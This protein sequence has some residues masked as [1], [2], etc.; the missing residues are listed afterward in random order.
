MG[1]GACAH[2]TCLTVLIGQLSLCSTSSNDLVPTRALSQIAPSVVLLV[3]THTHSLVALKQLSLC[4][5]SLFNR[6][7][8]QFRF[9]SCS[10]CLRSLCSQLSLNSVRAGARALGTFVDLRCTHTP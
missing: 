9:S 6:L 5:P 10:V 1:Y 7:D 4:S 8:S 3:G 2:L